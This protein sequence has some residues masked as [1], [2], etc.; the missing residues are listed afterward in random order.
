MA[1][2][3]EKYGKEYMQEYRRIRCTQSAFYRLGLTD[4]QRK[5]SNEKAKLRMQRLRQRRKAN[6]TGLPKKL[7]RKQ[8]QKKKKENENK[9]DYW[10]IKQQESRARRR[11]CNDIDSDTASPDS[12]QCNTPQP[13]SMGKNALKSA[14]GR[15]KLPKNTDNWVEVVSSLITSASPCKRR[16]LNLQNLFHWNSPCCDKQIN[17]S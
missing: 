15:I 12:S 17:F 13:V 10:R 7:T 8:L 6:T 2:V 14:L 16:T 11:L 3:E 4:E 5:A 9:K 1:Q